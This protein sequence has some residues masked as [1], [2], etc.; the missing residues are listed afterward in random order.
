MTACPHAA[1]RTRAAM[2]RIM[3]RN[4]LPS[5]P[6]RHSLRTMAREYDLHMDRPGPSLRIDYASELNAQQFEAVTAPPGP[7]LVLAGA[8]TGKTRTL[9]Y[10]VAW[11]IENGLPPHRILLLTFTNKAAKEMMTRVGN[12]LGGELPQLWGGTFHSIGLRILRLH[13]DRLGYRPDFT[14]ADR[15][16]VKDLLGSCIGESGVD[17]KATRFPKAD[18]LGDI[19]SAAANT[20]RSLADVLAQDHPTFAPL[21]PQIAAIQQRFAERKRRAGLMD[22]DDLLVL[23][24]RLLAEHED[25]RTLYQQRFQ[26]VLVDEYQDTNH[27]Q[28][29]LVD[30][31]AGLHRNLT[32]VG[33]D[34]Q[35]IY[36]WRGAD[37]SNILEFP[38]RHPGARVFRIETNYRST[39]QILDVANAAIAA[40]Q[41][42]FKK[43][44]HAH[45]PEGPVPAVV[46]AVSGTEQALFIAQRILQLRDEG[47]PLERIAVL[48]RSHFHAL[49]LQMELTRRNIPF[50]ITSGIRFFEQAHIKDVAA[51]LKLMVNPLDELAFHRLVKMLPGVGSKGAEKL[52]ELFRVHVEAR[53]ADIPVMP[54]N[55]PSD[56]DGEAPHRPPPGPRPSDCL[57][58]ALRSMGKSMPKRTSPHWDAMAKTLAQIADPDWRDHPGRCIAHI[59]E[60]GYKSY[61]EASY[62]NSRNRLDELGQLQSYAEQFHSAAE[63]LAQLALQTNLEAEASAAAPEDERLRLSTVHQAKGLEF[64]TV[65]VI[66]LC[67]GLFPTHRSLDRPDALEEERRLFYVA[68]TRAERELYLC[69]PLMRTVQGGDGYQQPSRFLDEIPP[70]LVELIQLKPVWGR[71]H[72][73]SA[74]R[75]DS[76]HPDYEAG[77][78]DPF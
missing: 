37:F 65:F 22:F 40:N 41:R 69:H 30:L 59:V 53:L 50:Y 64:D 67:D 18:A 48:Y 60:S 54:M 38:K 21:T 44:L 26:A 76:D 4:P 24:R 45:R 36:S 34:A 56:N 74:A 25:I 12:L 49:E 78:A 33:D 31:M 62:E 13:A 7:A 29:S 46:P 3:A 55:A 16:D 57:A 27:L 23:W 10:R 58:A 75:R 73:K 43:T 52:W 15:E 77:D 8:G 32:V 2:G 63:F 20:G 5:G 1:A 72:S 11:L 6:L 68:I 14:V 9:T 51:Y 28:A 17:V 61:V 42:Q 35:S 66:M 71:N 47:L 39:P 70:S 19:F